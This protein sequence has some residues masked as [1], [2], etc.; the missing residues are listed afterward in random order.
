MLDLD[1]TFS[2]ASDGYYEYLTLSPAPSRTSMS[3]K[4]TEGDLEDRWSYDGVPDVR[5]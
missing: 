5:A 4:T 2:K 1:E 3:S